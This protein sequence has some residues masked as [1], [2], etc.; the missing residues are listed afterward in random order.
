MKTFKEHNLKYL[1]QKMIRNIKIRNI[2]N[3]ITVPKS[4]PLVNVFT[5]FFQWKPFSKCFLY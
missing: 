1:G 4:I 5:N 2:F 3:F